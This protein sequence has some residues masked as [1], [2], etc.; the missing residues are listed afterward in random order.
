MISKFI[1]F[2]LARELIF[3]LSQLSNLYPLYTRNYG[4]FPNFIS[5]SLFLIPLSSSFSCV[6]TKLLYANSLAFFQP[7]ILRYIQGELT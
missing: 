6:I 4:K 2:H 7:L 5:L 1:F 3:W